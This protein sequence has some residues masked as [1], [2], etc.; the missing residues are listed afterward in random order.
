MNILP[1]VVTQDV[2]Q[3]QHQK[4]PQKKL[5]TSSSDKEVSPL[6]VVAAT[7]KKT[8]SK[9]AEILE[10]Y[11]KL[12]YQNNTIRLE[13]QKNTPYSCYSFIY[14]IICIQR[15]EWKCD[16]LFQEMLNCGTIF[17][18]KNSSCNMLIEDSWMHIFIVGCL[19]IYQKVYY[20]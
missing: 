12:E 4:V 15:F 6:L 19:V 10:I 20:Y 18:G 1:V 2:L 16:Q 17:R 8:I 3:Y 11:I 5:K 14:R 7:Y 13:S 9:H